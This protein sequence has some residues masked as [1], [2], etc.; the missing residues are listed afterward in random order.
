MKANQSLP[1]IY[2][3]ILNARE[4]AIYLM[5]ICIITK[6]NVLEPLDINHLEWK[7]RQLKLTFDDCQNANATNLYKCSPNNTIN[8]GSIYAQN[9]LS[10]LESVCKDIEPP[11]DWMYYLIIIFSAISFL[12]FIIILKFLI[13]KLLIFFPVLRNNQ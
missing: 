2:F 3:E 13:N 1:D 4:Y 5:R 11:Y 6:F 8:E 7:T 10:A 9:F 12:G